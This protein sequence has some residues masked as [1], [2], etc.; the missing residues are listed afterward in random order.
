MPVIRDRLAA[1]SGKGMYIRFTRRRLRRMTKHRML[2]SMVAASLCQVCMLQSGLQAAQA[3]SAT[4]GSVTILA[5]D[6]RYLAA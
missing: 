2:V 6:V 1:S 4:Q 3:S 5:A